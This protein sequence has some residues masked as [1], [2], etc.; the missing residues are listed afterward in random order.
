MNILIAVDSNYIVPAKVMLKS[1]SSHLSEKLDIY[2]LYS[3]LR[4]K[5]I[6][7]LSRFCMKE[8]GAELHP[9]Y[10]ERKTFNEMPLTG[11]FSVEVYFRLIAPFILPENIKRILWIDA[12]IIV[13][14]NISDLYNT[15][16]NNAAIGVVQDM[17]SR[18]LVSECCERLQLKNDSVYFNSGIILFDLVAIREHWT[19]QEFVNQMNSIHREKL[20]YPDQDMLNLIFEKNKLIMPDKWNYQ[21]RSWS[22]IK[23]TELE[24]AAIIHFVG[25]IKPWNFEY[26][27]KAGEIWW[28]Y[29]SLCDWKNGYCLLKIKNLYKRYIEVR[30]KHLKDKIRNRVK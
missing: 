30:L 23:T 19:R 13:K 14:K 28:K 17:G 6:E 3:S 1:L 11:W 9:M 12:D 7:D 26:G 27:N 4:E 24:D 5:H 16:L 20:I 18:N 15:N 21:I 8:C 29:Y 2:L 10:V 25:E 22:K